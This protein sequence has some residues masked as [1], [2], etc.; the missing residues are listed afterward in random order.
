MN[1]WHGGENI[2]RIS[3]MVFLRFKQDNPI[4]EGLMPEEASERPRKTLMSSHVKERVVVVESICKLVAAYYNAYLSDNILGGSD[5][6]RPTSFYYHG[7]KVIKDLID[8]RYTCYNL[9][10]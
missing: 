7:L 6:F 4:P 9:R 2:N 10:T 3:V 1:S 8:N 5:I